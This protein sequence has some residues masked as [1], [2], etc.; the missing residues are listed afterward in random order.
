MKEHLEKLVAEFN[1]QRT[2]KGRYVFMLD[3]PG[4]FKL[5]LDNDDTFAV[6]SDGV[7]KNFPVD[8]I[9]DI[10][11]KISEFNGYLGWS[12]GVISLLEAIGI[13]CESV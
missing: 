13:E 5:L 9:E 7:S 1:N 12:D 2:D 10:N 4:I 6:I 8:S 3:H 11:D